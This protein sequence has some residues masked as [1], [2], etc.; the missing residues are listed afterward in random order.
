MSP[1]RPRRRRRQHQGEVKERRRGRSQ[2]EKGTSV[3]RTQQ[4]IIQSR[5]AVSQSIYPGLHLN[6]VPPPSSSSWNYNDMWLDNRGGSRRE[7]PAAFRERSIFGNPTKR[8]GRKYRNFIHG[9][10]R[11]KKESRQGYIH[12]RMLRQGAPQKAPTTSPFMCTLYNNV[13]FQFPLFFAL[14]EW[15]ICT[16]KVWTTLSP[17]A[18]AL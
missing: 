3:K 8:E 16:G 10:G 12:L 1:M 2:T 18:G 14:H 7:S 6:I 13:T 4:T 11:D 17:L 5:P 9:S 15:G